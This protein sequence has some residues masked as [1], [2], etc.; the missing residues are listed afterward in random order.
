MPPLDWIRAF[1]AT[2]RLGSFTKAAEE[3]GITQS[4]ISQRITNLEKQIGTPLFQRNARSI[5]LTVAGEAWLPH[6]RG[7][8][9]ILHDSSETL[10]G[11]DRRSKLI[12]SASQSIIELWL[13]RRLPDL[14]TIA[15]GLLE[16]QTL[17]LGAN[18]APQDE[19]I[20]I[21]YGTGDAPHPF[22]HRLYG[23]KIAPVASPDFISRMTKE[24]GP[25]WTLWPRI[26]CSGARPGWREWSA[27]FGT[28]TTPL[29]QMRFDTFLPAL[30]AARAG[31]GVL[32][33]SL[34]LC[35][36]DLESGQLQRLTDAHLPHHASYWVLAGPDAI[37]RRGWDNLVNILR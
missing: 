15:G 32:L 17:I 19:I 28:A 34:P 11:R 22:R 18:E 14:Q 37:S 27:A 35:R 31:L 25:D 1:E 16:I 7:A 20:R 23:E 21:R 10:F 13:M 33:G 36:A 4:A 29:P 2:A 5:S 9:Q 12:L 6:V 26:S 8:M 30:G 24:H 3:T